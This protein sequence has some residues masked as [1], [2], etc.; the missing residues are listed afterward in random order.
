[1]QIDHRFS[2][3]RDAVDKIYAEAG[4]GLLFKAGKDFSLFIGKRRKPAYDLL[5]FKGVELTCVYELY[6]LRLRQCV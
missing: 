3:A 4:A 6:K 5:I 1:M 2:A